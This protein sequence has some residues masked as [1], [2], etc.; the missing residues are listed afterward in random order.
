MFKLGHFLQDVATEGGQGGPAP[1]PA[2]ASAP[3]PA[4]TPAVEPQTPTQPEPTVVPTVDYKRSATEQVQTL[5]TEA[6][7]NPAEVTKAIMAN[8]GQVTPEIYMALAAKHGEGVASLMV[9]QFASLAT[10][11]TSAATARDQAV[12]DQVAEAF[13]DQM[14]EGVDTGETAWAEVQEWAKE[15]VPAEERKEIN[16]LLAQ[17]GMAAKFAVQDLINRVQSGADFTQGAELL[18]GSSTS[19]SGGDKP[20]DKMTYNT[21]LNKLLDAGHRYESSPQIAQLQRQRSAGAA[22][23]L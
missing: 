1:T 18:D 21:E 11:A 2:P 13:K 17:G 15:N 16:K 10:E 22:R 23:G 6:G 9:N 8:G 12:Y 19:T 7:L 20:I 3:T 5:V 14:V 4:P